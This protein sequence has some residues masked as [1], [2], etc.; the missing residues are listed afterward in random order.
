MRFMAE[1]TVIWCSVRSH[2]GHNRRQWN[3]CRRASEE[4]SLINDECQKTG[5]YYR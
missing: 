2:V 3:D 1:R 5:K 4:E